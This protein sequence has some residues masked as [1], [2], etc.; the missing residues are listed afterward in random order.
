[1]NAK[2]GFLLF[3]GLEELDLVG[4]WEMISI[5]GKHY[6]G[7]QDIFTIS[8]DGDSIKCAKGLT[9]A[10]D[11]SFQSCPTPDYLLIPGG[12]GTRS[13][14]NNKKLI[15]FIQFQAKFCRKL[16]SVCTG[17][18]LLDAAGLLDGRKATTHWQ[19]LER[20]KQN[21]EIKVSEQRYVVDGNIWTSAGVSA[22]MDMALAF[23]AD[24]AGKEIAG[25][26]QLH[27]EYFPENIV[28]AKLD[29][30]VERPLYLNKYSS[31]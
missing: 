24:I 9:I 18:F 31:I 2:F 8:Q 10:A 29:E 20:L 3:N 16:L 13:E 26:V 22:G 27:A 25:K 15:D 17:S 6:N 19:S 7:P 21:K 14:M 30:V 23:I 1:M 4:P 28:Y 5:W 12:Q 11:Y